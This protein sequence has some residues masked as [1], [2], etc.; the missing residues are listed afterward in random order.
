MGSWWVLGRVIY[1]FSNCLF[2]LYLHIFPKPTP[3][4][5][6]CFRSIR[7]GCGR[8][9]I[10]IFGFDDCIKFVRF[11]NTRP[12]L[13]C[14]VLSKD[15]LV[16]FVL[17]LL[18]VL[19]HLHVLG[20]SLLFLQ[21]ILEE[22][23]I[24]FRKQINFLLVLSL[25]SSREK[26]SYL[27]VWRLESYLW[28]VM[29]LVLDLPNWTD[30]PSHDLSKLL[31]VPCFFEELRK[32]G[33][34]LVVDAVVCFKTFLH[35]SVFDLHEAFE[36]LDLVWADGSKV[37]KFMGKDASVFG[38]DT[39]LVDVDRVLELVSLDPLVVEVLWYNKVHSGKG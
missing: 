37:Q 33:N 31:D 26:L 15:D 34:Q 21:Q 13:L 36:E 9:R 18:H 28:I 10:K 19:V 27:V 8:F 1:G 7:V 25:C 17:L 12:K 30:L 16:S 29:I 20:Y 2:S 24:F 38:L 11:V 32:L 3:N 35:F 23:L 6:I 14:L 22:I 4:W 39:F 5:G